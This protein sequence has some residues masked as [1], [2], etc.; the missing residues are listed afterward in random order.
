MAGIPV[1]GVSSHPQISASVVTYNSAS[2]LPLFLEALRQQK[3]VTWE[4][5]FFDNASQDETRKLIEEWG[6]GDLLVAETNIG[7]GRAH[8]RNLARCRGK[9]VL[10]LNPDL[11]FGADLFARLSANLEEHREHALVGPRILEGPEKKPFPPRGFYPGE[12]MVALEPEL[13]RNKIAWLSG[14]CL[15]IRREVFEELGGFD[16]DYFL[17]QEDADLCLRARMAGHRIGYAPDAV[18][19]HLH[20]QSQRELSEYEYAFRIFQGSAVFWEK[21]YAPK[22]V[23]GMV[24]FQYWTSWLLLKLGRAR[25][26]LP[27]LPYAL[28]EARLR[29]RNDVCRRWLESHGHRLVGGHGRSGSIALRQCRLTLEWILQRRFP[30]DDY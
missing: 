30:L 26:L 22:D 19:H 24:R 9:L 21:H 3:D 5:L 17:Y 13:R 2:C 29:A 27:E 8:N 10:L 1:T 18:V 16:P 25:A 7:Y 6:P 28:S 20:R 11:S 23:L 12:G 15:M 14:C 4:A